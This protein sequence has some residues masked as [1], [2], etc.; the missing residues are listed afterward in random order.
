MDVLGGQDLEV[1]AV[2][3]ELGRKRKGLHGHE[4][5]VLADIRGVFERKSGM[6]YL[7]AFD[8]LQSDS[9]ERRFGPPNNAEAT[10]LFAHIA[11]GSILFADSAKAY[12]APAKARGLFLSCVDHGSGE[13]TRKEVIMGK[14]RTV[15]TQG[16]DGAWGNLKIW[17]AA[18]GGANTDHSL[19]Y[20]KEFQW[21]HNL[22]S[23]DPFVTLCEHIRD[24]F[25]Q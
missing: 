4:K 17:L 13:Y 14:M 8:K 11:P 20:L 22:G 1:E 18:K 12:I 3:S 9:D 10:A 19:G 16:I 21:R 15:S 2:E 23:A 7:E 25:L 5:Q 24:G 6:L